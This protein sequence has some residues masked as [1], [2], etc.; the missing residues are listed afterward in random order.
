MKLETTPIEYEQPEIDYK[1]FIE[2]D[3]S[4]TL[5]VYERKWYVDRLAPDVNIKVKTN[6]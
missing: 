6:N 1:K 5:Q 4:T 2:S 3:L